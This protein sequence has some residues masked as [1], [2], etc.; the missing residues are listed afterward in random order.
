MIQLTRRQAERRGITKTPPSG[1]PRRWF[2]PSSGQTI[3]VPHGIDPGWGYNP[4]KAAETVRFAEQAAVQLAQ[5][6]IATPAEIAAVPLTSAIIEQLTVAFGRW[7]R[8]LDLAKPAGDMRVVGTLNDDVLKFV[9]TPERGLDVGSGAITITDKA[10]AHILRDAKG[11][12]APSM[13]TMARLPELLAKPAAIL[14]DK[15]LQNLVYIVEE[16]GDRGTRFAVAIGRA[17][18]VRDAA[19]KRASIQTNSIFHGQRVGLEAYG[20]RRHFQ[21]IAGS[22]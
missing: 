22:L 8:A 6:L 19:G 5:K 20:D 4:G 15:E 7:L 11:A 14:W 1:P 18:K 2:N 12:L 9:Q 21:L 13:D 3:E 10:V 16:S 17:E